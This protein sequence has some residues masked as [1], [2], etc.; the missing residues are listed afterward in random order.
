MGR[1]TP[2]P[3]AVITNIFEGKMNY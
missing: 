1:E 2:S 3:F